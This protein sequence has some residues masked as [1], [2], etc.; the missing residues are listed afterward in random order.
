M[1][2]LEDKAAEL[3][4]HIDNV[5][6]CTRELVEMGCRVDHDLIGL[7][8]MAHPDT[9]LLVSQVAKRIPMGDA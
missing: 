7:Q 1:S 9:Q 6:I 8:S 3:R 2:I 4:S 5:N